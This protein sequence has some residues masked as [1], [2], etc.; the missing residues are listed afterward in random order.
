LLQ[1][2]ICAVPFCVAK[3]RQTTSLV[4]FHSLTC[5][6]YILLVLTL[7]RFILAGQAKCSSCLN[8]Y[9]FCCT[10]FCLRISSSLV[11]GMFILPCIM[12]C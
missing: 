5:R 2:N 6:Y 7:L 11:D 4:M 8:L 12:T 1:D 3:A 9:C 10:S